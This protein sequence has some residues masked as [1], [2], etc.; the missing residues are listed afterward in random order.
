[1]VLP[2]ARDAVVRGHPGDARDRVR[3]SRLLITQGSSIYGLPDAI[4]WLGQGDIGSSPSRSSLAALILAALHF[5][6]TRTRFG[7]NVYAVGGNPERPALSGVDVAGVKMAV[8]V[9]SAVLASI[10]GLIWPLGSTPGRERSAP[11]CYSTRSPQ[12]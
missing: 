2:S 4:A 3:A 11:T 8:L 7:L 6:L 9:L 12:W 1:V 10:G 5:A